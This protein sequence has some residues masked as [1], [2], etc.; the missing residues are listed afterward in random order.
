MD[1]DLYAR[2]SYLAIGYMRHE[3]LEGSRLA[4]Y[5]LNTMV[6]DRPEPSEA[7]RVAAAWGIGHAAPR[8]LLS[9]A[10]A[11]LF[12]RGG[13]VTNEAE[14]RGMMGAYLVVDEVTLAPNGAHDWYAVADTGLDHPA[15]LELARILDASDDE[16]RATLEAA[17]E[18]DRAGVQ[19]R[20]AAADATQYT[21]DEAATANHVA[22]VLFNV[23][24][25]GTFESDYD[26]PRRDLVS[27]LS[28]QNRVVASRHEAWLARLP[29]WTVL[30]QLLGD[31]LEQDDPQLTRL[32]RAY[33]PLTFSRRHGDP[34]RPWN[35]YTIRVHDGDE[36]VYGYEGNWRDIFQNWEALGISY[37]GYLRQ[38]ITVFLNASTADGYNP[39]RISRAGIDWEVEDPDDPWSHIGYW[40][41]HQVV[42]L[43]RL[44]EACERHEPGVLRGGLGER[45]Y[46]Y[47]DVPYRIGGF[48]ALVADPRHSITFDRARHEVL[49]GTAEELGADGRLI[50]EADGEVRLV[51]LAEKLLVPL[52]VKL[53]NL[54][55]GSG[56]WL[57]TQRPEWNDANNALAGWGV[58]VVTLNAIA[59]YARFL[60]G[61]FAGDDDVELSTSVRTLLDELIDILPAAELPTG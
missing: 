42:Y 46:S 45:I 43:L 58:S 5:T 54:V 37:P 33:L 38:F 24:R 30:D 59:R 52:L 17:L 26:V 2:L 19:R 53:T 57:N 16:V 60:L 25:G 28:D 9:D 32:L 20:L 8:I 49:L 41:D 23:M 6:S 3:R 48:D 18:A 15:V 13:A 39:Y 51:T 40:G 10:Q 47:A 50:R 4:L 27:Y 14:V 12:R 61:T 35:W 34:S 22:N 7:L 56:I 29:E 55:P 11:E 31:A 21:A 44:L 36:L 1:R